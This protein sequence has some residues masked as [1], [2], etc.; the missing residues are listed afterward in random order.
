M[1]EG[2]YQVAESVRDPETL[3]RELRPLKMIN[4]NY[5][6]YLLTLDEDDRMD[7]DGIIGEYVLEWMMK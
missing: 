3:A 5:P 7:Y 1:G 4:D 6:K 2:F